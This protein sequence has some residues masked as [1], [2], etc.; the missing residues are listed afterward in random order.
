MMQTRGRHN[1]MR[2]KKNVKKAVLSEF[3]T[4][5]YYKPSLHIMKKNL[6][7]SAKGCLSYPTIMWPGVHRPNGPV[8]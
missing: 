3:D 2:K 6:W 7:R 8:Y 1:K 4:S 5:T